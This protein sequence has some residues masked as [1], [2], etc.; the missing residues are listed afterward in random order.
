M[1]YLISTD[2]SDQ[3]VTDQHN[4]FQA[5]LVPTQLTHLIPETRHEQLYISSSDQSSV[6]PAN[7]IYDLIM[8]WL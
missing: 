8:Q 3:T 5:N 6:S 4:E 7:L 1:L 2:N